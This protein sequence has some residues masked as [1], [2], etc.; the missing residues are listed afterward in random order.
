[1]EEKMK[2]RKNKL[3]VIVLLT[4][5]MIIALFILTSCTGIEWNYV[6]DQ[7]GKVKD[8]VKEIGTAVYEKSADKLLEIF[9]DGY[10]KSLSLTEENKKSFDELCKVIPWLKKAAD[11]GA[12]FSKSV[13]EIK[14]I[15]T[16]IDATHAS[17]YT[18]FKDNE[19]NVQYEICFEMDRPEEIWY[20]TEVYLK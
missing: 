15:V 4:I 20:I 7:P 17:A 9:S 11:E 5:T 16:S 8:R 18:V 1:M 3:I 6:G 12:D 2:N 14:D 19:N 10:T 13:I